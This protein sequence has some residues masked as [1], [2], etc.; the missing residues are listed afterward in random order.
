[1]PASARIPSVRLWIV[2][3]IRH[4]KMN[5]YSRLS[6]VIGTFKVLDRIDAIASLGYR[7]TTF[8]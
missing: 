6:K 8:L 3:E 1:M 5:Q 4:K 7:F 2:L